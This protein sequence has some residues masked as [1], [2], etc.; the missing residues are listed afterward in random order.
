[1]I[2]PDPEQPLSE[3]DGDD[4]RDEMPPLGTIAFRE[5][6]ATVKLEGGEIDRDR[7]RARP[8]ADLIARYSDAVE[9]LG[10]R[11]AEGLATVDLSS[12]AF[13]NSVTI[14]FKVGDPENE[15][16]T[17][18]LQSASEEILNLVAQRDPEEVIH[19][20]HKHGFIV[21]NSVAKLVEAI[22]S[23]RAQTTWSGPSHDPIRITPGQ[24]AFIGKTL[25]NVEQGKPEE[26]VVT[27]VLNQADAKR[28][29]F[30][31]DVEDETSDVTT[32]SGTYLDDIESLVRTNWGRRVRATITR[33]EIR[34]AKTAKPK[35]VYELRSFGIKG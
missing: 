6:L 22:A 15:V 2:D 23:T 5:G 9:R 13:G 10:K 16:A 4:A 35:Y 14:E 34:R 17:Y 20:A 29:T 12:V 19:E 32:I 25:S 7:G 28:K 24:A 33:T 1:M 3:N 11:Y 31:L 21:A 26:I 30:R 27:G 18:G 8:I